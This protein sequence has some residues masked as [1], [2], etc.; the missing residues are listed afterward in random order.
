MYSN[1][2]AKKPETPVM[3]MQNGGHR[4]YGQVKNAMPASRSRKPDLAGDV[5]PHPCHHTA[6]RRLPGGVYAVP[7]AL[8]GCRWCFRTRL[9]SPCPPLQYGRRNRSKEGLL[10]AAG[11]PEPQF[12]NYAGYRRCRPCLRQRNRVPGENR[13]KKDNKYGAREAVPSTKTALKSAG[14]FQKTCADPRYRI[15]AWRCAQ[16]QDQRQIR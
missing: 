8:A 9:C 1:V 6:R 5:H 13:R 3:N 4:P 15:S 2:Q 10:R 14:R 11:L 16:R 12:P 7:W